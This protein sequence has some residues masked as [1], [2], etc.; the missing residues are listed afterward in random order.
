MSIFNEKQIK[1]RFTFNQFDTIDQTYCYDN[2]TIYIKNINF[3]E[4][5][6]EQLNKIKNSYSN[7]IIYLY[8]FFSIDIESKSYIFNI[9]DRI[10]YKSDNILEQLKSIV[11]I[12]KLEKIVVV[13]FGTFDLYHIGHQR[14]FERS[15]YYGDKIIVGVSSDELNEV[16]GKRSYQN[17]ETRLNVITQNTLVN[18]IFVEDSLELKNEYIKI[19]GGN[20]LVMGDDWVGK[21][22]WVDCL[23]VY[24]PRTPDIS[25]TMLREEIYSKK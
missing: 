24:L 9:V 2:S 5:N 21:F 18:S 20:I 6:Y 19:H 15:C 11:P 23:T 10:Y 3:L 22:D 7:V 16:K 4:Y 1:N 13:T 12:T 8:L 14:I 17:L 25:S